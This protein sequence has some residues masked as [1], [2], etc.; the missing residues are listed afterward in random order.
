MASRVAPW[1]LPLSAVIAFA[2]AVLLA[3]GPGRPVDADVFSGIGGTSFLVLSLTFVSV[4]AM[5]ARRVPGNRI[6]WIFCVIGLVGGITVLTWAYADYGLNATPH[7]IP[8]AAL[9]AVFPSEALAPLL[10]FALLVFPDGHLPSRRWRP[11]AAMLGLATA[12]LLVSDVVRPGVLDAPFGAAS[13]PLGIAGARGAANAMNAAGWVLVP[14][15]LALA[16]AS[17]IVRLRRADGVVRRQLELVLGVGALVAVVVA[18]DMTTW[19]IWPGGS[20][21]LRMA[22]IGISFSAF[23]A[24]T[25]VAIFRYRLYDIDLVINRTVVYTVLVASLA[26]LY[27]G[28][29]YVAQAALRSVSGQSS[30]LAVTASTLL[31]AVAFQPLRRRIQRTVDRRF[32]RSRYDAGRTVEALALRLGRLVDIES[33]RGE[34]LAAVNE[35]LHPAHATLW[36]RPRD[37]VTDPERTPGTT[38]VS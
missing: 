21:Q 6:G 1:A 12:L 35:T 20:L 2:S 14:V 8:G 11:V 37:P 9:A 4:G 34:V 30:T 7:A 38:E 36:L 10:G 17:L 18:V 19:L 16:A 33:T 22:A 3:L 29:V 15:G 27:F 5:V 24:A 31:V 23:P 25:G 32:Y 28:G 13:N 26:V